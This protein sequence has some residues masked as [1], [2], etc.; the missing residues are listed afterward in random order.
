MTK[1]YLFLFLISNGGAG[2]EKCVYIIHCQNPEKKFQSSVVILS[3][4]LCASLS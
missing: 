1:D 3:M 2:Y 4:I